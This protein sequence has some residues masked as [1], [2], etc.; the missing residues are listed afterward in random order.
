MTIEWDG[1]EPYD[2]GVADPPNRLS[3]SEA[4]QVFKRRMGAKSA[5][6]EMLGRLLKAN[7]VELG[8]DD[9]AIQDLND[10]FLASVE[11]NPQQPGRLASDWYSVA[12]DVALFLGEVMIERHPHLHWEFFTWGKTNVAFQR[13][14]IMGFSTEDP[15]FH[16]NVDIGPDRARPTRTNIEARG[17]IPAYGT[18]EV[19]GARVGRGCCCCGSPLRA[20]SRTR[21]R[22][23][24]GSGAASWGLDRRLDSEPVSQGGGR[25]STDS[26]RLWESC[27]ESLRGTERRSSRSVQLPPRPA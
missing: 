24:T 2:P 1:Y 27:K 14:V 20:G 18:V 25:R 6:I 5:R 13:H 22:S 10:W 11:A 3:R 4:R 21:R 15:K 8:T 26:M 16:T 9:A 17:S 7:G 19:R 23:G 12:H